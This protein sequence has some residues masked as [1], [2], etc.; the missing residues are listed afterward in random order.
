MRLVVLFL[1]ISA[2]AC[3]ITALAADDAASACAPGL[4][5]AL[6][7]DPSKE[8]NDRAELSGVV[9]KDDLLLT[10]SNEALDEPEHRQYGVQIFRGTPAAGY[11]FVRDVTIYEAPR[12]TCNEADF[13]G[14]TRKGDAYFAVGS[15]SLDRAKQDKDNDR[16]TN[17]RNLTRAGISACQSRDQLL[18]FRIGPGPNVDALERISLRELIAGDEVVAPFATVPNKENGVDIEGLAAMND[19]LYVGFRGPVLRQNYV[20][21]LRISQTLTASA[22][23]SSEILFVD[24]GGR[25]V[26][27]LAPADNSILILAG[28]NGDEHQTFAIYLWDGLSDLGGDGRKGKEPEL[29]CDLGLNGYDDR[30]SKPEGIALLDGTPDNLRILLVYDGK[31]PLRAEMRTVVRRK[32]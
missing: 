3:T 5:V 1:L 21:I 16:A 10:L 28:P 17:F 27:D 18:K 4:P 15:H 20:P 9:I 2:N 32:R 29:L 23:T 13:E 25:G 6:K 14:L 8:T 30:K 19:D 24:L 31:A 22:L 7:I 12:G 11:H 26:R